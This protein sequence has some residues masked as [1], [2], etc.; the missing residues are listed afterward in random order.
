MKLRHF[1][2][3][4]ALA[5][6]TAP[7]F[8]ADPELTVFDWAG[9]EEPDIY[10]GYIDKHGTGPTFAF[11]GNDDEAFQKLASGFRADV[12]HPCSQMVSK[13]RDAG[14]IEPWD[15]SRIPDFE[16]ID[17]RFL[18]SNVIKD[19][20]GVWYIP[21]DWGVTAVAY[22]NERVPAEDVSTL[23][24]FVNPEYQGRTSLPDSSDDVWALAYL[25]TGTTDW[26]DVSDEEFTK[27]A[28]WLRQAHQNVA[29]Y[30]S[31]PTQMSQLMASGA[32]DV[33][34]SWNDG[35]VYL[36]DDNYDVGFQ[37]EATEGSSTWFCGWVN[38]KNGPGSEDKAY[39]FINAW[40]APTAAR[41]L[42]DK[43]GYGSTNVKGMET[44]SP[45]ELKEIG[46][47]EIDVPILAQTPND[48]EQRQRQL[49]E[50]ERIKAGF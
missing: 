22:S 45:E 3:T 20:E 15:I 42:L 32:A 50:F 21:G 11:Y 19:D 37:R 23:Q 28:D 18:E 29:A 34:W 2:L 38:L 13:Y 48:P 10:Q 36:R 26:D 16:N 8:A 33:A 49:A 39:D 46:L 9:F 17:P 30:W 7:A 6:L 31:D 43:I 35:V 24:V 1:A 44:I 12:A 27:A 47:S 14:L 25:A 5:T 40:I 41:G 4:S